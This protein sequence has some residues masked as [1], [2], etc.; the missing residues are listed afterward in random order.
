MM[1]GLVQDEGQ[2]FLKF[3]LALILFTGSVSQKLFSS[4]LGSLWLLL[5]N[6]GCGIVSFCSIGFS[7]FGFCFRWRFY[8][9]WLR[10]S[11]DFQHCVP[12]FFSGCRLQLCLPADLL[13]I[14]DF[15]ILVTGGD[16][17]ISVRDLPT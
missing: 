16:M 5:S 13:L 8:S 2:F 15:V 14:S 3:I 6:E 12:V 9:R 10:G 11:D 4:S 17:G 1:L 7:K